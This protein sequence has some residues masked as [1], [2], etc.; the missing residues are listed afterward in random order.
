M[1]S[2]MSNEQKLEI[3]RMTRSKDRNDRILGFHLLYT[4]WNRI[5][6]STNQANVITHRIL[7]SFPDGVIFG[8]GTV[9]YRPEEDK[10]QLF[11]LLKLLRRGGHI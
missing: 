4:H 6:I 7:N 5:R 10:E 11:Q 3:L 8:K 2:L 9:W 1:D